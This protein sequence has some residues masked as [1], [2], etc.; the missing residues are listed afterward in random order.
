MRSL[1]IEK[2]VEKWILIY[3]GAVSFIV[4]P[5][6]M[7]HG[8]SVLI[9]A[10]A[11]AYLYTAIPAIVAAIVVEAAELASEKDTDK[12]GST[13]KSNGG[14]RLTAS[15]II[16]I[17]IG[18]WALC[19]SCLSRSFKLS[20]M[21][22][23]GWSV[24]S[25]MIAVL[26]METIYVSRHFQ[27]NMYMASAVLAV[28]IFINMFAIIQSAGIDLFGLSKN[29]S[30]AQYYTF[31]STIGQK[32]S[33]SGYLC[34]ILPLFWGA[35]ILC[36]DRAKTALYGLFAVIGFM[37]II[38]AESD[39]AYAGIGICVLFMLP[40]IFGSEQYIKRASVLLT[41]YGCCLILAGCLPVFAD[42]REG[43]S[44]ISE[45]MTGLPAAAAICA[46]GVFLYLCG[47]RLARGKRGKIILTVLEIAAAAL[48]C[49]YVVYTAAHFSDDWGTERGIIWRV[50]WERFLQFPLRNK[51]AGVG[52]ELLV[53]V[54]GEIRDATGKNVVSAHCEPLNILLTQ[55]IAGLGIYIAFWGYLLKLYFEKKLWRRRSAIFFF[56]LAAYWGQSLFCSVYPV[57][58]ALFSFVSGM[59]LNKTEYKN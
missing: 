35:F 10:K 11:G 59:F 28:N 55:G 2:K 56:P 21:G 54:F 25:L 52:P 34:L 57:T 53:T 7:R 3:L 46:C 29:I 12:K 33:Y 4:V 47:G 41:M 5:L 20:L 37:G 48:I 18:A 50:G 49:S 23:A 26:V 40:F 9:A 38:M 42:K 17:F 51:I 44:G 6:Y 13:K 16:L 45:K 39:S 43:F 31:L 32:N 30:G 27:Y 14:K 24:G 15:L 19:S 36:E 22:T 8:Y 58:A 1:D